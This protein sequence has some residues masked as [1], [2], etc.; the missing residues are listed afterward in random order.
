[1]LTQADYDETVDIAF[2]VVEQIGATMPGAAGYLSGVLQEERMRER[3]RTD[4]RCIV[5]GDLRSQHTKDPADW[6]DIPGCTGAYF[7]PSRL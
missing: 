7:S 2:R 1:M 6:R 5:C 3:T 4:P